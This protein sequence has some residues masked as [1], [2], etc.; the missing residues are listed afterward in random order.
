[1]QRIEHQPGLEVVA[2][3]RTHHG[4]FNRAGPAWQVRR[5]GEG[6]A[7]PTQPGEFHTPLVPRIVRQ[8]SHV[9]CFHQLHMMAQS[10]IP[11]EYFRIDGSAI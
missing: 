4:V 3:L 6:R 2:V 8:L 5:K 9:G 11:D 1:M 7:S 10:K